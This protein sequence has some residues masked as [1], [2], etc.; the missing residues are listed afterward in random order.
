MEAEIR[1][2]SGFA[3][4][5]RGVAAHSADA[6][7]RLSPPAVGAVHFVSR[8]LQHGIEQT[9]T[10]V[11]DGELRRVHADGHAPGAGGDVVPRERALTAFVQATFGGQR[12]GVRRDDGASC[13]DT[14]NVGP[15]AAS[16]S[17]SAGSILEMGRLTRRFAAASNPVRDPRDLLI[18]GH[19][20][21]SEQS[22]R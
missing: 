8:E 1:Q 18:D 22:T 7:E 5:L 17:E 20:R 15:R 11:A 19:V 21:Q 10:R 3:R 2:T 13:D 12:E 4:G 6:H 14:L 16:C 9:H